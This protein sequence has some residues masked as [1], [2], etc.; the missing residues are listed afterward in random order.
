MRKKKIINRNNKKFLYSDPSDPAA[1]TF[2][3][4]F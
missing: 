3:I 4:L 1:K 2:L